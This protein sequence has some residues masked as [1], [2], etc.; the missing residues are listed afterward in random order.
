MTVYRIVLPDGT[1]RLH[2]AATVEG[3]PNF[4]KLIDASGRVVACYRNHGF[5][6]FEP[7]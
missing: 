5:V 1:E 6:L 7:A 4:L 2:E 3:G